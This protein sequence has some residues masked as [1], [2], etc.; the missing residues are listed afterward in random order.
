M[1]R[2]SPPGSGGQLRRVGLAALL[3]MSLGLIV[4]VIGQ[5]FST[6]G[7]VRALEDVVLGVIVATALMGTVALV[8]VRLAGWRDPESETE[9]EE[10]VRQSERLA[11]EDADVRAGER[12]CAVLGGEWRARRHK[13]QGERCADRRP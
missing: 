13:D 7:A 10:I 8:A 6:I 9:F 12:N 3:A 11:R 5:G 4:I 1:K 2:S